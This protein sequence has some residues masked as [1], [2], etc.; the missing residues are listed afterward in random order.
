MVHELFCKGDRTK[1]DYFFKLNA[2]DFLNHYC[3][4]IDK[5]ELTKNKDAITTDTD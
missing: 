2:Y 1:M 3:Y 4:L 5:N